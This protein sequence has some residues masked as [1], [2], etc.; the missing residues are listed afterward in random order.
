ML[1]AGGVLTFLVAWE[2]MA[3]LCYLLILHRPRSNQVAGG[4]FWFLALSETGF[5]LIV[6]AFVILATKT[7]SM[8]LDV[9]A[10]RA[11]LVPGWLAGRR[12]PAGADRIRVQGRAWCRCT[13]GCRPRT[14]SR[15]PTAR[16]SCPA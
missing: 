12:L 9:I 3:L 13:S 14:R 10:A 11:H 4:A 6:A 2:T 15:Q 8:Q 5:V 7:H 1:A 16:R